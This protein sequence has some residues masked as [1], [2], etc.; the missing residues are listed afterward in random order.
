MLQVPT[1][2]TFIVSYRVLVRHKLRYDDDDM[3]FRYFLR[4]VGLMT[5]GLAVASLVAILAKYQ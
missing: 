2:T 4:G 1:V 5:V 3:F